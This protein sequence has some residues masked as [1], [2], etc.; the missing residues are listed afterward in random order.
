MKVQ[1]GL[2]FLNNN[3]GANDGGALNAISLGQVE[4]TNGSKLIFQNNSG[5]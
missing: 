4:L 1:G 2:I 3:A 5:K